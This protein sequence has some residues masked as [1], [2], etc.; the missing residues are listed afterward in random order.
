MADAESAPLLLQLPDTCLLAVLQCLADDPASLCSAAR[1][2]SRLHQ[3]AVLELNSIRKSINTEQQLDSSLLP[4]LAKHGQHVNHI[5]L[6]VP[7]LS[8]RPTVSLRQLPQPGRQ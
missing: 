4:Y 8:S 1:A 2:H 6:Y 3:A 7:F 5:Y